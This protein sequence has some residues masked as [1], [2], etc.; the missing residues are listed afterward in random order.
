LW[1]APTTPK[2]KSSRSSKSL[3]AAKPPY[4]ALKT[5]EVLMDNGQWTIS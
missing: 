1:A 4:I 3:S 5:T 2:N